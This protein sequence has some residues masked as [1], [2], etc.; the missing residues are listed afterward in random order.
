MN[1]VVH[2]LIQTLT[3]STSPSLCGMQGPYLAKP[4]IPEE[5]GR[6]RIDSMF[7]RGCI[8]LTLKLEDSIA[9]LTCYALILHSSTPYCCRSPW[10]KRKEV[11]LSQPVSRET[12]W[13]N[14]SML[15]P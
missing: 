1:S 12:S 10:R 5:C 3:T 8:P 4:L 15:I 11:L 14:P 9:W 2:Q 7:L 6:T 13:L